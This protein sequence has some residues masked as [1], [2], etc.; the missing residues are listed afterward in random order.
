VS[1]QG[2]IKAMK[3]L[4]I[5]LLLLSINLI[6]SAEALTF[7]NGKAQSSQESYL[8]KLPDCKSSS[9]YKHNCFG[10]Y[11]NADGSKYV[12]EYKNGKRHGQCTYNYAG[13]VI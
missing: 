4:S 2:R 12:G 1:K 5:L 10:T 13:G 8:N 6:G 3:K 9:T 11:T 7:K